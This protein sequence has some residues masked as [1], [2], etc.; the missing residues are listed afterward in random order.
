L[1]DA[2][3]IPYEPNCKKDEIMPALKSAEA[4]GLFESQ[5][6]DREKLL[7]VGARPDAVR[8]AKQRLAE[9]QSMRFQ[10]RGEAV[11]AE[12]NTSPD[13]SG[14][15]IK[16]RGPKHRWTLMQGGEMV[17]SGMADKAEAEARAKEFKGA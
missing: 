17:A 13:A 15:E 3:G 1:A 6:I 12:P 10:H 7:P 2:Y 5:P 11:E 16:W 14:V 8:A 9:R 4:S